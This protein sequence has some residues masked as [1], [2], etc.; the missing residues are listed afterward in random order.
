MMKAN[1]HIHTNMSDGRKSVIKMVEE[2]RDHNFSALAKTDHDTV[3]CDGIAQMTC[4]RLDIKYISGVEITACCKS[5]IVDQVGKSCVAHILGLGFDREKMESELSEITF[6]K[7]DLIMELAN[8]LVKDGYDIDADCFFND[9][10]GK[11][12]KRALARE[13][14]KRGY[15]ESTFDAFDKILNLDKYASFTNYPST[16]ETI[17]AIKNA[18]GYAILA[19]PYRLL[20]GATRSLN[21]DEVER[22]SKELKSEGLDGLEVYYLQFSNEEICKLEQIADRL[23]LLKSVGTDYHAIDDKETE[24]LDDERIENYTN[25]AKTLIDKLLNKA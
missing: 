21:A 13:L 3:K 12:S 25:K 4:D 5:G 22:L 24:L 15:A 6:K 1:L 7:E 8:V 23:D 16:S 17:K 9:G 18:D 2:M 20:G 14:V 19:H 10:A 11:I